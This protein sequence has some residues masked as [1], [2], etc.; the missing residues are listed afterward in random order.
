MRKF[1][2]SVLLLAG[3][4]GIVGCG[5]EPRHPVSGLVTLNGEPV[6]Q[7]RIFFGP[8]DE[9][10]RHQPT[11]TIGSDGRY[12]VSTGGKLG[13]PAGKYLATIVVEEKGTSTVIPEQYGDPNK[14][15]LKVEITKD[16]QAGA[17]DLK[18]TGEGSK[19]AQTA[20]KPK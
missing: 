18:L 15:P 19:L 11:A 5:G 20:D 3:F 6:T 16:A 4:L 1:K 7:G 17:Y 12:Q 14:T 2:C 8:T 9:K 13:A 10:N